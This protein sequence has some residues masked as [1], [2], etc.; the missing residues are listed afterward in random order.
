MKQSRLILTVLA[1]GYAFL[2]IPLFS[3][4]FYSFN[5]SKL[6]TV[7]G[8]FSTRWYGELFRNEQILDAAVLSLQVA[9][10]SATL[11]AASASSASKA[12]AAWSALT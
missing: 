8:G 6:A 9:A 2:Y 4:I 11:G 1:F 3:V 10:T 7:W 12:C 5:D